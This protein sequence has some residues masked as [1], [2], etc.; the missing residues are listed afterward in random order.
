MPVAVRAEQLLAL[1]TD[2]F[3]YKKTKAMVS[4]AKL[5]TSA[6]AIA[7]DVH[8]DN[9]TLVELIGGL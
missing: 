1:G 9:V 3:L 8:K 5:P 4:I 7:N 2:V 6:S